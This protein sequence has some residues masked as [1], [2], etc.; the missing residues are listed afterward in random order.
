MKERLEKTANT[1]SINRIIFTIVTTAI[2]IQGIIWIVDSIYIFRSDIEDIHQIQTDFIKAELKERVASVIDYSDYRSQETEKVLREELHSRT[3]EAYALMN[4][5]YESN[6]ETKSKE[7]ITKMIKDAL[8]EIRFNE[9]R[10]YYFI[11]TLEGDVILYPVIPENEGKNLINLKDDMGNYTLQDEI[12]LVK[13]Q[14]EGFIEAY[15]KNPSLDDDK[16]YKKVSFVKAFEPYGWYLG[17]GDYLDE[18][19]KEI[20]SEVLDY[21]DSIQYGEDDGQY[22]FLHDYNGVELANGVYPEMVGVNNYDLEDINGAKVYQEQI[23]ICLE[24]GGG[25]LTHF[26]PNVEDSGHHKKLTYVAPLPK[27]EWIIG[28]GLDVTSLDLLI[29][30]KEAEL[31]HSIIFRGIVILIVLGVILTVTMYH[32]KMFTK[33]VKKNFSVF[34]DYMISANK[35]LAPIDIE[36]LDYVDFSELADVTNSMT[37][38]INRL[39]NY[40]EL[41][42]IYNRRHIKE[43]YNESI[44]RFPDRTGIIIMDVD[45]FKKVNDKY[46]HDIGDETLMIIAGLLKD[47]SQGLGHVGRFGGEEFIAVL[48]DVSFQETTEVAERIRKNI[49]A[50]HMP[51]IDGHVTI[52]CGVA[53]SSVWK[54]EDLFKQ[55]DKKLYLAKEMGRNRTES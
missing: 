48:E 14:G 13:L 31:R 19:T 24:Q 33:K 41:T 11:D 42:G 7:E 39:L 36:S 43:I 47:T 44:E 45:Y 38:R 21:V 50:F 4:S 53:H 23:K 15:W 54:K 6:K 30:E 18:I 16:T 3:Y 8:R 32:V 9:G 55:A 2:L 20:Q 10:G 17:C 49:E 1:I 27:W 5:I 40:D 37:K 26:W 25:Y 51:S 34:R 52:S 22:V 28:T 29:E 46:G 12:N 35:M